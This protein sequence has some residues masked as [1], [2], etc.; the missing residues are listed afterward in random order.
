MQENEIVEKLARMLE[1]KRLQHSIEVKKS[2]RELA[3]IY[4]EDADSAA[5]AGLLHDCAKG[6]DDD[7]LLQKCREYEIELDWISKCQKGLIHGPLGAKIARYEFGVED[8]RILSAI[9]YHTYGRKG[10]TVLEKVI[11][12]ADLIEPGRSFPGVEDLRALA[13]KDLDGAM[14]KALDGSII[15]I[16][17]KRGLIHPNTLDARNDLIKELKLR[18]KN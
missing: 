15:L 13:Y 2:A 12:L 3:L 16:I 7:E 4:K 9:E 6:F 18:N 14:L 5:L 10:M 11:Y 17:S 1:P 8:S